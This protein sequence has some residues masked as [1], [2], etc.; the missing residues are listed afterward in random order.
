M[1][2]EKQQAEVQFWTNLYKELGNEGFNEL[3]RKDY[4]EKTKHFK[5]LEEETGVGID[6]G[7]GLKSIFEHSSLN[8]VAVDPLMDE[9]K[10][11][12]NFSGAKNIVYLKADCEDLPLNEGYFDFAVCINVLDH[13]HNPEKLLNEVKRVVKKGGKFYFQVN[14]DDYLAKPHYFLYYPGLLEKQMNG[15]KLLSEYTELNPKD[16]QKIYNAVYEV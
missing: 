8:I 10:Q 16:N 6:M 5:G 14:F 13:T 4:Q 7:C 3:R 2:N 12:T 11:I 1:M 9:Y 15:F